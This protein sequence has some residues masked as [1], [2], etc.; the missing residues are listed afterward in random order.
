MNAGISCC[1]LTFNPII[2]RFSEIESSRSGLR[3]L[4]HSGLPTFRAAADLR[5]SLGLWITRWAFALMSSRMLCPVFWRKVSKLS[6]FSRCRMP[7]FL[8]SA[9]RSRKPG[10]VLYKTMNGYCKRVEGRQ[11]EDM[12]SDCCFV[13]PG[14]CTF[15]KSFGC[16][17]KP[18]SRHAKD[19]VHLMAQHS[20]VK[21][22]E[23]TSRVVA[24]HRRSAALHWTAAFT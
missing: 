11:E 22:N 6:S 20:T 23:I 16:K 19:D 7:T 2:A 14:C 8:L 17:G 21:N 9:L 3:F 18:Q 10:A 4:T 12:C 13:S 5:F 15:I 24:F 1:L